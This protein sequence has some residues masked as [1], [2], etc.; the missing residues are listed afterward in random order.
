MSHRFGSDWEMGDVIHVT[1]PMEAL[2]LAVGVNPNDVH[3]PSFVPDP[4]DGDAIWDDYYA[5]IALSEEIGD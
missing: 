3:D 1:D 4:Y 2:G 5:N